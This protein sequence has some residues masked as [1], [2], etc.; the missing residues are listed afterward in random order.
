[1]HMITQYTYSAQSIWYKH[2]EIHSFIHQVFIVD[3]LFR[4]CP[5]KS[6]SQDSITYLLKLITRVVVTRAFEPGLSQ[7]SHSSQLYP[8]LPQNSHIKQLLSWASRSL[9]P[10]ETHYKLYSLEELESLC[11]YIEFSPRNLNMHEVSLFTSQSVWPNS[12]CWFL[13]E[14]WS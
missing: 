14:S 10:L 9:S 13:L 2:E 11:D 3:L 1:M 12:S 7:L 5:Q 4:V 8:H 6:K